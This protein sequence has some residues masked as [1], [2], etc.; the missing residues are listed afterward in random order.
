MPKNSA[1]SSR[2]SA[3]PEIPHSWGLAT[4]P[5]GVWPNKSEPA[6]WVLRANRRELIASGAL[7]RTGKSLVVL[8]RGYA[9]WLSQRAAE[10]EDY[11]SNNPAMRPSD[12]PDAAA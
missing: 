2:A 12:A 6:R 9:R 11:Q 3:T 10:V 1:K 4:W 8:G 5:P 7:A